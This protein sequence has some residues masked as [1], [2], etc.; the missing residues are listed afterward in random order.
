[1]PSLLLALLASSPLPVRGLP[2]Y[3]ERVSVSSG[4]P[5]NLDCGSPSISA[6]G[7]FVAFLSGASNL[8]PGDTNGMADV[9]VHDRQTGIA[10]RV[11][12]DSAG[13]QANDRT[14]PDLSISADG[15]HVAFASW[16][17][18]LVPGDTPNTTDIFV[19]ERQS[20]QTVRVSVDSGGA[21]ANGESFSPKLSFDGRYVAF[22][23][24]ATNLVPGDT[25]GHTD[26][27]I[28]D[29]QT[30]LTTLESVNSAGIQGDSSS[31]R[32]S[33]SADGRYLVFESSSGNLGVP[34]IGG[35]IHV[36]VRDRQTGQTSRVS[37]DSG[38]AAGDWGGG[39]GSIS[40]DGRYVAFYSFATDLVLGDT[41]DRPDIFVHDRQTGHTERV[42]IDSAGLQSDGASDAASISADGRFVAFNSDATNLVSG[43]SSGLYHVF[44]HDRQTGETTCV[45]LNL[46][47]VPGNGDSFDPHITPNGRQIAFGSRATDLVRRARR[48]TSHIF[49]HDRRSIT[50][51]IAAFGACPGQLTI[52]IDSV[53]PKDEVVIALG[54]VGTFI[55]TAG[56]CAGTTLDLSNPWRGPTLYASWQGTITRTILTT[57]ALCGFF[58]QALDVRTCKTSNTILL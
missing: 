32:P 5:A 33:I 49:V 3:T 7:R 19:H 46:D 6:D 40:D 23:S 17:S 20:R 57:P 13:L 14:W 52:T 39:G 41:N 25:N 53:T 48:G 30:G 8:V 2:Q 12:V 37:V 10:S 26:V 43:D 28:H 18:N 44:I 45:D 24:N 11:S 22:H 34:G 54:G 50:P 1:M 9:F 35:R 51:A 47:G 4:F 56:R 42:S 58:V 36:Y 15:N 16:A 29:R 31:Y 27:F 21:Q 38:G 55:L